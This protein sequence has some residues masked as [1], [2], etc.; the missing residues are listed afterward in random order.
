MLFRSQDSTE[1]RYFPL[2]AL[3]RNFCDLGNDA[4]EYIRQKSDIAEKNIDIINTLYTE[5]N[6]SLRGLDNIDY[7]L[8]EF[9]GNKDAIIELYKNIVEKAKPLIPQ[10]ADNPVLQE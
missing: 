1:Q 5:A 8:D 9:N 3:Y 10:D 7:E 2:F 6:A 4:R